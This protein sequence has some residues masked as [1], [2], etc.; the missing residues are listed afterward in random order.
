MFANLLIGLREGLEAS[1]IVGI[2]VAYALK[3]GNKKSA[4][5]ILWGTL[6]AVL[7]SI[8]VGVALAEF[9]AVVPEG[10]NEIIAGVASII[11][12]IF[13]TWMIFWMAR[14]SRNL[15]SEL[16]SKIDNAKQNNFTLVA[17]AFFA[18]IRE[19]IET[20]VFIWSASRATG[21]DTN[22]I[23]GATL[24]LSIAA[25]AGYLVYRG[26]LKLNLS[27]FFQYTGAFLIVVAAGIFA[28]GIHELQ[29]VGLLP[30][31]TQTTYD[32]SGVIEKDGWLDT[33]L[34]GTISFRSK[35]SYLESIIW[36][37]YLIT[38]GWLYLKPQKKN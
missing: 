19:G 36:F 26:A 6:L 18:V 25:V 33:L 1:L 23:F 14:Q 17:V 28:Y 20:A 12:V 27:K 21:E 8:G 2:L 3:T 11:A 32:L 31:L 4:T 16:H 34:R 7:V 29:E 37:G 5:N 15:K 22:P 30:F 9:V 10:T 35:P 38:V 13:V 24:G